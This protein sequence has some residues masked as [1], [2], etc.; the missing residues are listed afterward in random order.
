[1]PH[2]DVRRPVPSVVLWDIDRYRQGIRST[3]FVNAPPGILFP[4]DPGFELA[5]NGANAAKP[6]ANLFNP[7][8]KNLAPRLGFA[9]DVE[10]NGR[11]SI[12]ASYGIS[13]DDY[14]TVDRLGTQGS[15]APYGSLTRLLAPV[16]GF[17]DPWRGVPGGNPF[18]LNVTQNVP[19]V[20]F[21][22]YVFRK[23][24][25]VP[26][27]TQ[28]W[29]L[30]VQRE[31]VR[32]TLLSLS[33]IGSQI[34]HLQS[35]V[36]VN[37][38]IYV[39]G[40]GNANGNCFLNGQV[41]YFK[42]TPGAD[43]STLANTQDRRVLSFLNPAFKDEIGRLAVVDNGGT[44]N[45]NGMLVS[46]QRRPSRGINLNANYTLSHCIGDYQARSNNGYGPSVDH[47]YQDP[48]DRR[49]DRGNCE[50]DQRHNFNLT[51]VVESPQFANRTLSLVGSGWRLSGIYRR[52]TSGTVIEASQAL[53]LRTVTLGAQAGNKLSAAGGD[54]CLCDISNQR[55]NQL[56]ADV[57]LDKS[58]RPS[59]QYLNPAIGTP[60]SA[61]GL[62]AIGT[63]GNMGRATLRL[64]TWWQFD[65][66]LA[67]IFRFRE[68]QSL[69]FRAEAYNVL[70]SFRT[71]AI[72]TNLSSAQFGKIRN[73]LDQR[74]LQF[75]LKYLF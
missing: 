8:W 62:P 49:R 1:L 50:I 34:T 48:N 12:R 46:I 42:V 10:G 54:L 51:G 72:D 67:R 2:Q 64:P 41:T 7:Y 11:T 4:G 32:D 58:G 59:T 73:A 52:A 33:Y 21:G 56:L 30:S 70:N 66:A 28:T 38:S 29:N 9:W 19:F 36:S 74:I 53:G 23:P 40:V 14:P 63:L 5:N 26:T 45:Y 61:F 25:L 6:R 15:M 16:G 75:A 3:V 17:E 44:Q 24:D 39:P 13:Y 35:A 60:G 43:C 27:Y 47:T 57:Y 71:G 31:V 69:E 22:E 65:M 20:P 37:Q 55:P 18:P 68:V